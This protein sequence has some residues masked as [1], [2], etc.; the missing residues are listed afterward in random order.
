MFPSVRRVFGIWAGFL[1]VAALAAAADW[2]Q[3]LGAKRDGSSPETGLLTTWPAEGPK[4]L[5]KVESGDGYS[6]VAVV[7]NRAYTMVQRGADELVIALDTANG[8]EV[9]K[10]RSGPA[11]KNDMGSGP[12]STPAIDGKFVY[13]Q[14]A[15]GPLVCLGV[16]KGEV[17]WQVDLLKEFRAKNISWGLSASP[18]IYGDLVLAE[19]GGR[20]AG[21]VALKKK[22]GKLDWKIGD[23]KAAYA[24]PVLAMI[25]GRDQAIFFTAAGL[26]GMQPKFGKELWRIPWETEYD[27]NIATPLVIGDKVFV[28][29]G[30]KV[31]CALF[32]IDGAKKP[33][34]VWESKG[35]KSVMINYW[36]TAVAHDKHLYGPAGEYDKVADLNCV[37]LTNGKIAWSQPKFG[38]SSVTLADGHLFITTRNGELVLAAASPKAYQ[39]KARIKLLEKGRYAVAPTIA[40]KKLYLRDRKHVYCLDIAGKK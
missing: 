13:V 1:C 22:D 4:V 29:S 40:D 15:S 17:V 35:A 28:S 21:M 39:E 31:G 16:D 6:T 2:P 18:L 30:E 11:Y 8:N 12:R 37:D 27:C 25:N 23:D 14:S 20:G 19:P 38:L 34:V 7:G 33:E 24:S 3:W 10:T 5:W 36:A 32:R 26:V 9:W